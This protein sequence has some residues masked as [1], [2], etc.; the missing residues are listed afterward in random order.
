MLQILAHPQ[1]DPRPVVDRVDR[2]HCIGIGKRYPGWRTRFPC[3]I[4][5][6]IVKEPFDLLWSRFMAWTASVQPHVKRPP[7]NARQRL[8]GD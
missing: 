8:E 2:N 1:C 4:E 3:R 6:S 7:G 5:Q